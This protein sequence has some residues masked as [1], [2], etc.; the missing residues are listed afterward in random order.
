METYLQYFCNI[1]TAAKR[2]NMPIF[3]A[4]NLWIALIMNEL[5]Q[6]YARITFLRESGIRMKDIAEMTGFSPSVLSAVYTTVLPAYFRNI[7]QGEGEDEA[8]DHALVWVNNVSKKKLLGSVPSMLSSLS[9]M[10]SPSGAGTFS[11]ASNPFLSAVGKGMSDAVKG[12][13]P[14]SGT[15]LSY[16][17]S[18]SSRRLKIEPYMIAVSENG[19][20]VEVLHSS[21]YGSMH[22]G[23]AMMNGSSHLYITFNES[24]GSQ[25]SLFYI[26]LKIPMYDRPPFLRG[27]YMCMDY[28]FNPIARRIL[29]V[30][31]SDSTDRDKFMPLH[32]EIKD[33]SQLTDIEKKYYDYTCGPEDSLRLCNIPSPQMTLDDLAQEKEML[34]NL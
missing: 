9:A 31:Q 34:K 10:D 18:S 7:E 15:Y 12:I 20:Y 22:K 4:A 11:G 21:A 23:A 14:F 25:L 26:C 29:F 19:L 24:Q 16:S 1:Q 33:S 13:A 5:R 3:T 28:N 17:V 6:I 27:I 30:K 32:G 2:E 8:L